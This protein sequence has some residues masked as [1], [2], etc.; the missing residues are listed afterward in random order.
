MKGLIK[1]VC[2]PLAVLVILS[3]TGITVFAAPSK[4]YR[5]S[6]LSENNREVEEIAVGLEERYGITLHYPTVTGQDGAQM[7]NIVPQTLVTL[8]EALVKVTPRLVRQVSAY[9]Y[10]RNDRRLTY[11]YIYADLRGPYGF[12]KKDEVQV[13]GFTR[14]SSRIELFLPL[15]NGEAIAT[16][17][18]PLTIVH[19]LGHA[20]HFM[21]ADQYGYARM[22]QEWL[23]LM[24]GYSYGSKEADPNVF[25]TPYAASEFDED[26]AETFAHVFICDRPGLGLSGRMSQEGAL[27]PLGMKIAYLEKLLVRYM[28]ENTRMLEN[29]RKVYNTPVSANE[30]GLRLAGTHLFFIG[31]EE[32]RTIPL[33]LLNNL[34]VKESQSLW[35]SNLGGW[36]CQDASGNHL[37]LFPEGTYGN[38]GRSLA[39]YQAEQERMA[40]EAERERLEREAERER[41]EQEALMEDAPLEGIQPT[42]PPEIE[43]A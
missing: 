15:Y 42:A 24:E 28:G 9:Y 39:G 4:T 6:D 10:E 21:L 14:N 29:Y 5:V 31:M 12:Q 40:Q 25:V 38:T 35:I 13:G 32:P 26:F 34:E 17:D 8:D 33:M 3:T 11:E 19:E 18:N 27:T 2:L 37:L 7:A 16:G 36:Y 30:A 43:A 23:A 20:V 22:E 41:L 1:W